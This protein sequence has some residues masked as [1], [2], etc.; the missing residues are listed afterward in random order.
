MTPLRMLLEG[1]RSRTLM[2]WYSSILVFTQMNGSTSNHP[3]RWLEPVCASDMTVT[4]SQWI[5]S[6]VSYFKLIIIYCS[7]RKSSWESHHWEYQRLYLCIYGRLRGCLCW[8]HDNKSEIILWL[9][10]LKALFILILY[11]ASIHVSLLSNV[12][13]YCSST[14]MINLPSTTMHTTA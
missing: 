12:C 4:V 11:I 3:S 1:V 7:S 14:L 8:L 9:F 6:F 5:Y 13:D 2:A 10:I